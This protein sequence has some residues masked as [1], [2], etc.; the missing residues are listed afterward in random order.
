VHALLGICTAIVTISPSLSGEGTPA[1]V[2]LIIVPVAAALMSGAHSGM[3]WSFIVTAILMTY[4]TQFPFSDADRKLAWL[5][6]IMAGGGGLAATLIERARE[7]AN[8]QAKVDARDRL[9]AEKA[10]RE[11]QVLFAAAFRRSPSI[12]VLISVE[13]GRILDANESF[14]QLSGWSMP[15]A[16]GKTFSELNIWASPDDQHTLRKHA[17][18][19]GKME[20]LEVR[21]RAKSGALIWLLAS[22]EVL[23]G[24]GRGCV[25]V[26]GT[27]I[28]D[29]KRSDDE[30]KERFAERGEQ[31]QE[32]REQ[33]R[34]QDRLAAVGT[35]AAGVAH[36]INN[37][38]GGIVAATEFAMISDSDPDR[39]K[40]RTEAIAVALKEAKRCGRIVRNV[41]KF[42]RDEPT[43]KWIEDLTPIVAGAVEL[44]R[45]H[46]ITRRGR[47]ELD[48]STSPLLIRVSPIDI[49]QVVLNLV[50]NASESK[51]DGAVIRVQTLRRNDFAEIVVADNGNGI[52]PEI[53]P[54]ILEPFYTSRVNEGGSGLG[55]SVV[56]G[57]VRDHGGELEIEN[58]PGGGTRIR[59]LLPL[60]LENASPP[61]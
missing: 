36:Q 23:P 52:D 10:L 51:Q 31:L 28:T 37:P 41:L 44:A 27:D 12:M 25:L 49:E 26:Q 8:R 15:E 18:A 47:L 14:V 7:E 20:S 17:T 19:K 46:V 48:L 21:V 57:I 45:T 30:L 59:V 16:L 13:T 33:L 3:V 38:I 58:L 34:H 61:A 11:S 50:H 9:L 43:A 6:T 40:I 35:L 2:A 42:S 53:L 1:L 22:V 4:A 32:S 56:H 60:V 39:E 54:R 24:E 55:L 29:R 5:T